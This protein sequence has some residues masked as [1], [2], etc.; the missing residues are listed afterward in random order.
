MIMTVLIL[1]RVDGPAVVDL[2]GVDLDE[3]DLE[4]VDLHCAFRKVAR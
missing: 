2:H 4:G 3:V 1:K